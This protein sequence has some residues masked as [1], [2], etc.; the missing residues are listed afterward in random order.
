MYFTRN[1]SCAY[2]GQ[3]ANY[4]DLIVPT[5]RP[6]AAIQKANTF[7]GVVTIVAPVFRRRTPWL[8]HVVIV[9]QIMCIL[10]PYLEDDGIFVYGSSATSPHQSRFVIITTPCVS[11]TLDC[12]EVIV[13]GILVVLGQFVRHQQCG[14]PRQRSGSES[15][16]RKE[17]EDLSA[18]VG[19]WSPQVGDATEGEE[20]E[21]G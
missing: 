17:K 13:L 21:Q 6:W 4:T 7:I 14:Y 16:K 20:V 18:V 1:N 19:G 5:P 3:N 12:I 11:P 2:N 9:A 10:V 8:V 15:Q